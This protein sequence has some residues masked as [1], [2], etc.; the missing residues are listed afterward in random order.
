MRLLLLFRL[1]S[2]RR[3]FNLRPFF[4]SHPLYRGVLE[5]QRKTPGFPEKSPEKECIR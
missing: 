5:N 1:L 3:R 2:K 4:V